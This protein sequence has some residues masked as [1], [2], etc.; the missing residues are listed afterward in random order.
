MKKKKINLFD[1]WETIGI[2]R[3]FGGIYGTDRLI[4]MCNIKP[5]MK[6]LGIGCGTG[7]TACLLAK[8]RRCKVV[9][10]DINAFM[11]K[12]A[13]KRAKKEGVGDKVKIIKADAHKLPFKKNTFDAVIIESVL[14]FCDK[15]RVLSEVR[16]VL[17]PKGVV[18]DNEL[19]YVKKPPKEL[20]SVFL[21]I[22]GKDTSKCTKKDWREVYKRAG[23]K[24]RSKVYPLNS[25]EEF[26]S[27]IVI[28]GVVG[29]F[30]AFIK[31]F[32]DPGLREMLFD[33]KLMRVA[34]KSRAYL[35]YGLY[36]GRKRKKK[37]KKKKVKK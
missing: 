30:S 11:V 20:L 2:T 33:R 7:Y 17:K 29:Y 21:D 32:L 31:G 23:F 25:W 6:V 3:H 22:V 34:F 13:K 15:K 27:H 8:K 5:G 28:N 37:S 9:A 12:E 16:R 18:G 26:V 10:I 4:K 19:T 14:V 24:V 1:T 36:V 35:G